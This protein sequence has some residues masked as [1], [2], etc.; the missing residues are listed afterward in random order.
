MSI[1]TR[2]AEIQAAF[3]QQL[4][5]V[6]AVSFDVFDTLFVRLLHEPEA[7]FD[8][9]GLQLNIDGFRH[10]RTEAQVKGF[11]KMHLEGRRE[12]RLDDIYH[13]VC[14]ATNGATQYSELEQELEH[15][16]LRPNPEV[17]ALLEEAQQHGKIVALTS[18]MY[19]PQAFFQTM[20]ER[21]GIQVDHLLISSACDSTKR[22]EGALF[23]KL[24]ER[25]NVDAS[26]ILHVGDNPLGDV[27]RAR[28][29]GLHSLLY[30]P[31]TFPP[32]SQPTA[33]NSVALGLSRYAAYQPE[34]CAWRQLGWQYGGPV[35]SDFLEWLRAQARL[36]TID[37]T[38]F[39]SRDG[40]LLHKLHRELPNGAGRSAYLRGSRV[41]FT[42]AG[43]TEQNFLQHVPFLL[44]GSEHI[45]LH[46]LL[47][48]IGL[49]L[50][51]ERVL[52]D[53]GLSSSTTI[54]KDNLKLAER[55]LVAMRPSILKLAQNARRGL[56]QHLLHLGLEDGMRIAFVDVGWSGTT[57]AAFQSA[58]AGLIKFDLVGYYFALAEPSE[59]IR[60]KK[61]IELRAYTERTGV[62]AQQLKALYQNRAVAELFFS[63]PHHTTIGY[64]Y[65]PQQGL[66]FIEDCERG[67]D[68]EIHPIVES[69]NQGIMDYVRQAD[70]LYQRFGRPAPNRLATENLLHLLNHP[71]PSQVA[72]IGKIHNWDAWASSEHYLTYFANSTTTEGRT[73]PDLWPAGW[74]SL[75]SEL[76]AAKN[77]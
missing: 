17:V 33:L 25:L 31:P 15:L 28:E 50:P 62:K 44:S 63:A 41:S 13:Y 8:L 69:I 71:S 6:K 39:V 42:L 29:Q 52:L 34:V 35:L 4:P 64:S 67:V 48:R 59:Q 5:Q 60:K 26:D 72:L 75:K 76:A 1:C 49:D 55:F 53:L 68:Y 57:Q 27:Q 3:R 47:C 21:A 77:L 38:L 61:S 14:P 43:L 12:I 2:Y 73:K 51:D 70:Q 58:C 7:L 65:T 18:D 23:A 19:L 20:L 40:Y 74:A 66:R 46:D 37:L 30:R 45:T 56:Y 54:S 16:L 10:I 11:Q 9:M 32:I 24:R 36:D 22:D